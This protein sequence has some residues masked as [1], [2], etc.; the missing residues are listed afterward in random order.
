MPDYT[1]ALSVKSTLQG[2]R[3]IIEDVRIGGFGIVYTC[4][5]SVLTGRGKVA[6]K[7]CYRDA[8]M[9]RDPQTGD[10]TDKSEIFVEDNKKLKEDFKKE[11]DLLGRIS[12]SL[13]HVPKVYD[14]FS[15]HNT[16]YYIMEFIQGRSLY[17][18]VSRE[19]IDY[20]TDKILNRKIP[21]IRYFIE[22]ASDLNRLHDLDGQYKIYHRDISLKNII[23][24]LDPN[25]Q[26]TGFK[27]ID[28]G[29]ARDF[30]LPGSEDTAVCGT[31]GYLSKR[32]KVKDIGPWIDTYALCVTLHNFLCWGKCD[33]ALTDIRECTN[34]SDL[35]KAFAE[36]TVYK[37]TAGLADVI[38]KGTNL[39][40]DK[41]YQ[42]MDELIAALRRVIKPKP[43]KPPKYSLFITLALMILVSLITAVIMHIEPDKFAGIDTVT[44]RIRPSEELTISQYNTSY[45]EL[46]SILDDFA[47]E[48]KYSIIANP[49]S[50]DI[51]VK[52]PL[53]SFN[54]QPIDD[55]INNQLWPLT[56]PKKTS[57]KGYQIKGE[58]E[59]SSDSCGKNQVTINEMKEPY[60]VVAYKI[61][62]TQL[63]SK[64]VYDSDMARI[65]SRLDTLNCRYAF[66]QLYGIDM[67][68][69]I[70][71]IPET[72]CNHVV[73]Q[74]LGTDFLTVRCD[75][76]DKYA[77]DDS[78]SILDPAVP[79]AK[80]NAAVFQT[81]DGTYGLRLYSSV[82]IPKL[83]S[84][85]RS[86]NLSRAY[87]LSGLDFDLLVGYE[88]T[89]LASS[90]ISDL[91]PPD[92]EYIEFTSFDFSGGTQIHEDRKYLLDFLCALV[93]EPLSYDYV[94]S[95]GN[96]YK[97]RQFQYGIGQ[98]KSD[99]DFL[100]SFLMEDKDD[101]VADIDATYTVG[102]IVKFG[103]YPQT[104]SGTDS[105]PIEW[106][107][108][109]IQSETSQALLVSRY[110]LDA[111]P[112]NEEFGYFWEWSTTSLCHWLFNDFYLKAFTPGE[113]DSILTS[114]TSGPV[115]LLSEEE[116]N[117]YFVYE[118]RPLGEYAQVRPTAYA[119]ARGADRNSDSIGWWWLKT[120][121]FG[122][123]KVVNEYGSIDEYIED[124]TTGS[125]RPAI[126]ISLD[127]A[128]LI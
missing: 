117:K 118:N 105:T 22:I 70:I 63:V 100:N 14:W 20:Y 38:R 32:A 61:Q 125:V 113:A 112:Y 5:D 126:W 122:N 18:L 49:D 127:S 19:S 47:G 50:R 73:Q 106:I 79:G 71:A 104:A 11:A 13:S 96:L 114:H 12:Q 56:L 53:D 26:I 115:S 89:L 108:V 16:V 92:Q 120:D 124:L 76:I 40:G 87:L 107:I 128:C 75:E 84:Y 91:I 65:K 68:G 37:E 86:N 2:G 48:D 34:D 54:D 85:M 36:Q 9:Q 97:D 44:F 30:S 109:D 23:A 60:V 51:D 24:E 82:G 95:Y 101:N 66:G 77:Y 42:S 94:Y 45:V 43:P 110:G 46:A 80:K 59:P 74:S 39:N 123:V 102:Q 41:Q 83:Y 17:E 81:P 3:Y 21:I 69:F 4:S 55:V 25:N 62:T 90:D 35:E 1:F 98:V 15:E 121:E 7:E 93:N 58:W 52:L 27:L 72:V 111:Q 8:T 6:I 33:I 57:S 88:R 99:I 116:A 28:F 67:G 10:V 119:I 103:H 64:S 29:A 78:V 31:D